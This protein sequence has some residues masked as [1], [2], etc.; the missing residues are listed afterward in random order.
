MSSHHHHRT[1]SYHISSLGQLDKL[2]KRFSPKKFLENN[3]YKELYQNGECDRFV[4]P[5]SLYQHYH[6]HHET[7]VDT[8]NH[9]IDYATSIKHYS[10]DTEDQL[11]PPPQPSKG[12]LIQIEFINMN[13][14]SIVVLIETLRLPP[15]DS[16][17]FIK[18]KELC[19][20]VFSNNNTIYSWGSFEKEMGKFYEFKL[21]NHQTID[22]I[23]SINIQNRFKDWFNRNNPTSPYIKIKSNE[24]YS[25]QSAIY[26]CF[27]EWLDK[28]MTFADWGYGVD[29]QLTMFIGRQR[30]LTEEEINIKQLM[31]LYAVHDCF[32]VS[33]LAY[34]V[35]SPD[36]LPS[37]P[38]TTYEQ[39]STQSDDD[40]MGRIDEKEPIRLCSINDKEEIAV[41]IQNEWEL[42]DDVI[43]SY[44]LEHDTQ[45]MVHENYNI[46][47]GLENISEVE[48]EGSDERIPPL[49]KYILNK[50]PLSKTQ[51]NNRKKRMNRYRFEVIRR[52][53]YAFTITKIKL[54]L[55][56]MNI[57]WVNINL[58][59]NILFIGL[60]NNH[61]RLQVEN[62]LHQ[63]IFT[64]EHFQRLGRRH[65]R[66]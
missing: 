48:G 20:I 26:L 41:H 8:L 47:D 29:T 59:R 65:R 34:R 54:I 51:R 3:Q 43:D 44:E 18:I 7:P 31:V 13:Y 32:A 11:Q 49:D 10:I 45:L 24:T 60:K 38:T 19:D 21:L 17:L 12:A 35:L 9:L 62:L 4:I 63:G 27:N 25:L 50:K 55:T 46:M 14:Q 58:Y 2:T 28:R 52:I 15:E 16:Q 36:E 57:Y 6:I 40:Q 66:Y 22:D 30:Q 56:S 53:Y 5:S 1:Y 42:N 61:V 37:S 33:K 64:R 39:A 23:I